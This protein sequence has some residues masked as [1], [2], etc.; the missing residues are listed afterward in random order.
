MRIDPSLHREHSWRVHELAP[1]FEVIDLWRFDLGP[2]TPELSAVLE[3]VVDPD[4]ELG[5]APRCKRP[6]TELPARAQS[7]ATDLARLV[8]R[9]RVQA[10]DRKRHDGSGARDRP[11][12]EGVGRIEAD[13]STSHEPDGEQ[14]RPHPP[15]LT[16]SASPDQVKFQ[17]ASDAGADE[18][19]VCTNWTA[20]GTHR[21]RSGEE[22]F[23]RGR[24]SSHAR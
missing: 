24:H 14:H 17:T 16:V 5:H 2:G 21:A 9:T 15:S 19:P 3:R 10:A 23:P 8:Q 1:D 7:P 11:I 20:P 18:G 22:L 4:D 12:I 13:A 6:V